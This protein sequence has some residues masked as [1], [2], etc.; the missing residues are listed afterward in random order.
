MDF[1]L[2]V[3]WW[4]ARSKHQNPRGKL[5]RKTQ[6]W[7]SHVLSGKLQSYMMMEVWDNIQAASPSPWPGSCEDNRWLKRRRRFHRARVSPP[8]GRC[9]GQSSR[10][11]D[12]GERPGFSCTRG[13]SFLMCDINHPWFRG[14]KKRWCSQVPTQRDYGI[15]WKSTAGMGRSPQAGNMNSLMPG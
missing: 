10:N 9:A 4:P 14:M 8:N 13:C 12:G 15:F 5:C 3:P 1:R 6:Q 7:L 2:S 11:Q